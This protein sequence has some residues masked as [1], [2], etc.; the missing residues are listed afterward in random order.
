MGAPCASAARTGT[1]PCAFRTNAASGYTDNSFLITVRGT[2]A[3][4]ASAMGPFILNM[5][6]ASRHTFAT[7]WR[8][9]QWSGVLP[10]ASWVAAPDRNLSRSTFTTS[11][12]GRGTLTAW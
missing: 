7:R 9:R 12:D 4:E 2:N 3:F 10:W 5:R 8:T 11:N 1:N 6:G